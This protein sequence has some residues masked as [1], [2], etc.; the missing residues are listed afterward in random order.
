MFGLELD[1]INL[2]LTIKVEPRPC[3][4][5]RTLFTVSFVLQSR[6]QPYSP[7]SD[8]EIT[9]QA[10]LTYPRSP[11]SEK[12]SWDLNLCLCDIKVQHLAPCDPLAS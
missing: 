8:E 6:Y 9:A 7:F 10:E 3:P 5:L 11:S 2:L 4:M 1:S 12:Y